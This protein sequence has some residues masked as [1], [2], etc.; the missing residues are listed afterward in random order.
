[1][2][3]NTTPHATTILCYGASN[4]YGQKPDRSGRYAANERW[5]GILQNAL[6]STFYIIE[7]GLNGRTTDLEHP[8]PTKPNRNGLTY[9]K[10]CLESHMPLSAIIVM[11][12]TNDLKT[13][14]NRS[15]QDIA[16]ALRHYPEYVRELCTVRSLPVPKVILVSPP[17]M[18]SQA[19][20][21]INSMPTAGIYDE[22]SDQKSHE[23]GKF[24]E[25]V[26]L[27]T[28]SLFLDAGPITHTGEDGCHLD[29]SS[30]TTLAAALQKLIATD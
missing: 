13:T 12:G 3:M 17:Y 25:H 27:E 11:L 1:M 24:I 19:S 29:A 10:A 26:A 6:G 28:D 7:E 18:D 30:H 23:L 16:E 8:N 22:T 9:F 15:A 2:R 4:T 14:Y 21:F 5:T 20:Q